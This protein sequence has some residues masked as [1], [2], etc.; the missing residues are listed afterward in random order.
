MKLVFVSSSNQELG[1]LDLNGFY[2]IYFCALNFINFLI[3]IHC[4]L[5]QGQIYL[6]NTTSCH[7]WKVVLSKVIEFNYLKLNQI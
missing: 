4:C 6:D 5:V 7:K 3:G 1:N 2:L